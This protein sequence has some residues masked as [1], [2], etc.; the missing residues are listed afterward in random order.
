MAHPDMVIPRRKFL[1]P[2]IILA[3]TSILAFIAL[4]Q[5]WS[6][7]QDELLLQ[8]GDVA[9][10]DLRAP[11]NIQYVSEVL[12]GQAKEE[13][14]RTVA[15]VYRPPDSSIGRARVDLLT[16]YL[17]QID[18]I[19]SSAP[20]ITFEQKLNDLVTLQGLGLSTDSASSVL[21][22]AVERWEL[23][24][25]EA[26]SLLGRTMGSSVR[27]EDIETI[28]QNLGSSVSFTLT[29][30]E[31]EIVVVLVS[32]WIVANSFYDPELTEAARLAARETVEPVTQSYLQGQAIVLRGQ[33]VTDVIYEALNQAGLVQLENP[34]YEYLGALALVTACSLLLVLYYSRRKTALLN[35]L[36]GLLLVAGLFLLFLFAGRV[37]IPNRTL[38]PYLFPVPA[39]ALFVSAF[40]G[41]ERGML[42][43][44]LMG[45]ILPFGLP[46]SQALIPYYVLTSCCG[47]L[48]LGQARRMVQFIYAALV[49]SA[50]GM[51]SIIAYRF[52]FSETDWIG[53]IT[54]FG[55]TL[56]YGIA[57]SVL[58]LPLQTIFSQF[59]GVTTPMQLLDIS[60][61]DSRLLKYLLQ[62]APGTYQHSLYVANVAEQAAERIGADPLLTRVGAL[63][64]DIGKAANPLFFVENQPPNQIN[65]HDDLPP[66]E[67][68]ATIIRHV[69]DGLELAKKYRLPRRL[70]DFIAEHHGTLMTRYQYNRA[71]QKAQGDASR[72]DENLFRYPGPAPH[73][74]E[75]AILMF[76]DGVEARAR[77]EQPGTEEEM[78][79]L[80]QDVIASR[81]KEGQINHTALT[82]HDLAEITGSFIS[83]LQV[84]YH[85]RLEYPQQPLPA[86]TVPVTRRRKKSN[87]QP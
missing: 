67:S 15:P 7:R 9:Q 31:S 22:L 23:V 51:A 72:V 66:E 11:S 19:R 36:R 35:D 26:I 70:G 46:D 77:A 52:A 42:F 78:R 80:V 58:V 27:T 82:Q 17:E 14:E 76:A 32:P 56:V 39:F 4:I 5:P 45:I 59:L 53:L 47:V 54:L 55:T 57:S 86:D 61:P 38:V 3:C 37:L 49:I 65:S 25:S 69:T 1:L 12:T 84:T 18:T 62:R 24:Q 6:L 33:L 81:Q 43:G 64:H 2:I 73:S 50:V 40:Y 87:D 41:L 85:P 74:K 79:Q 10:Q 20:E 29:E 34:L 83:T 71:L 63:F 60:R 44:L 28:R 21:N 75:T 30:H 48:A 13:A 8:V 68:A 16:Q